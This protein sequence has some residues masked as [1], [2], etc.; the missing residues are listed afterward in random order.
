M[1]FTIT[2]VAITVVLLA[3]IAFFVAPL[4][5]VGD[6]R[7][8][9]ADAAGEGTYSFALRP[10][11]LPHWECTTRNGDQTDVLDLGMWPQA[12]E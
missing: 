3:I 4:T 1:R 6:V 9:C 5:R 8:L 12:T 11:P 2:V 10:F 7:Q